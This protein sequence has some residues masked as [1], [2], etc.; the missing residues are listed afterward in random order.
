[1]IWASVV[2]TVKCTGWRTAVSIWRKRRFTRLTFICLWC[3]NRIIFCYR[4]KPL[5]VFP[6]CF[7]P[8]APPESDSST[9]TGKTNHTEDAELCD[10]TLYSSVGIT[11]GQYSTLSIFNK[12]LRKVRHCNRNPPNS[13]LWSER[14]AQFELVFM[15]FV[16][17]MYRTANP[18]KCPL[19]FV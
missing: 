6:E 15:H 17:E 10:W 18:D 2:C 13:F 1:M 14:Q 11:F 8:H 9:T 16:L 3:G 12:N 19:M 7:V 5:F 4:I